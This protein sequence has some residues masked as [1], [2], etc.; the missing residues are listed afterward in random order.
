MTSGQGTMAIPFAVTD[1]T[2]SSSPFTGYCV[3][4]YHDQYQPVDYTAPTYSVAALA[5]SSILANAFPY[6]GYSDLANRFNYMGYLYNA[7]HTAGIAGDSEVAGAI[8]LALWTLVDSK[9]SYSTGDTYLSTDTAIL[10]GLMGT[11]SQS[12]VGRQQPI[13][14]AHAFEWAVV[15][16]GPAQRVR[17]GRELQRTERGTDPV[18]SHPREPRPQPEP[19]HLGPEHQ[20]PERP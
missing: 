4:L 16:C 10:L 11:P 1:T 6:T 5:G 7:L 19:A 3:D 14:Q 20:H 8:Q 18:A 9:F 15:E 17:D 12:R 2:T 13:D